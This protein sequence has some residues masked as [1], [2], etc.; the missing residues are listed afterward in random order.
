MLK[1]SEIIK[2]PVNKTM[3]LDNMVVMRS[4]S[5]R[6]VPVWFNRTRRAEYVNS[7]YR[8]I[9]IRICLHKQK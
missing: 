1:T 7:I 8:F 5:V 4:I 9:G 3:R 6:Q 2:N